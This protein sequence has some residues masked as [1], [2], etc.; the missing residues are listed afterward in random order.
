MG[1]R[2]GET[3]WSTADN[4]HIQVFHATGTVMGALEKNRFSA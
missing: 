1:E 3:G 4:S 2:T